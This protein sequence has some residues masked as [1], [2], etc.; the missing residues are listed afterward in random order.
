[1]IWEE[2]SAFLPPSLALPFAEM[3][4]NQP[5]MGVS[6]MWLSF[7]SFRF[8][9]SIL[10]FIHSFISSI[11]VERSFRVGSACY[12]YCEEIDKACPPELTLKTHHLGVESD[13]SF[14]QV[15]R[16]QHH[17]LQ[18]AVHTADLTLGG[19]ESGTTPGP[20]CGQ[21]QCGRCSD[22]RCTS[23]WALATFFLLFLHA[24]FLE[25]F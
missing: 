15:T 16:P 4:L 7:K 25:T 11:F 9:S 23:T 2:D 6:L 24:L 18:N 1:M 22:G 12:G 21:G 3:C 17:H 19:Y 10:F 13:T 8:S 14:G 20:V 5:L